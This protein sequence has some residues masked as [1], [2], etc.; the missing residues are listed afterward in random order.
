MEKPIPRV[1]VSLSS[2]GLAAGFGSGKPELPLLQ[3]GPGPGIFLKPGG[4]RP[5]PT[6]RG[7]GDPKKWGSKNFTQKKDPKNFQPSAGPKV[8][9]GGGGGPAGPAPG[10]TTLKRSLT[11]TVG[12]Q[13]GPIGH[14]P[15]IGHEGWPPCI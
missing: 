11:G 7:S 2:A 15:W 9:G 6:Q 14:R 13:P 5:G 4:V 8:A 1:R 3:L 12:G 10:G